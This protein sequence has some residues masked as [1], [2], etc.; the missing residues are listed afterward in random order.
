[1]LMPERTSGFGK[2][3]LEWK[4]LAPC[5]S[6]SNGPKA[7]A[8]EN[9][10]TLSSSNAANAL[11]SPF[12]LRYSRTRASQTIEVP[13]DSISCAINPCSIHHKQDRQ[14]DV[15]SR[16]IGGMCCLNFKPMCGEL[17]LLSRRILLR[18][19]RASRACSPRTHPRTTPSAIRRQRKP[20]GN[21][22][23]GGGRLL[24]QRRPPMTASSMPA[25]L[26]WEEWNRAR[27]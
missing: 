8:K 21:N 24:M 7:N 5:Q 25:N 19:A 22:G 15:S 4:A 17:N 12:F 26:R 1:M 16:N 11:D 20:P 14:Q 9:H 13:S 23:G 10:R 18:I 3:P 6:S 2:P 27:S